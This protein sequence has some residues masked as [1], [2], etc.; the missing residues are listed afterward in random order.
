MKQSDIRKGQIV[1]IT[2]NVPDEGDI[3]GPKA[4]DF[5]MRH[6][7]KEGTLCSV[8]EMHLHFIHAGHYR[9]IE[10]V[11]NGDLPKEQWV[12]YDYFELSVNSLAVP[13]QTKGT[14]PPI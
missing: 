6:Y 1:V 11:Y 5:R 3:H 9:L 7:H 14:L 4:S 12:H 10:L 8:G 13:V 2:G